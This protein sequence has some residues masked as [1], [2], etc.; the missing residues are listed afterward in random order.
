[1]GDVGDTTGF[2][3]PVAVSVLMDG[4]SFR[5]FGSLEAIPGIAFLTIAIWGSA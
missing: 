4:A 1:M 3:P 2:A 5:G